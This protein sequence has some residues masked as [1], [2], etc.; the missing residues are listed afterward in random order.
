MGEINN[1]EWNIG[2]R[3]FG[4][5]DTDY[6]DDIRPL[7]HTFKDIH[8][9]DWL[10]QMAKSVGLEVNMDKTKSMRLGTKTPLYLNNLRCQ[11]ALLFW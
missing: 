6:A 10:V 3:L 8:K 7:L 5:E 2:R 4:L 1:M 11:L 9:N